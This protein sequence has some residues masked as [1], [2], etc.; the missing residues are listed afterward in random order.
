[1]GTI[2]KKVLI[3]QHID[4]N[5][6]A[7]KYYPYSPLCYACDKGNLKMVKLLVEEGADVNSPARV[8]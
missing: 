4:D 1:M 2:G 7:D 6:A 5:N 3:E 8:S